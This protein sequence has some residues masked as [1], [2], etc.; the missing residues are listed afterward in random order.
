LRVSGSP[1]VGLAV[2]IIWVGYVHLLGLASTVL[3]LGA[4]GDALPPVVV[5]FDPNGPQRPNGP[6]PLRLSVRSDRPATGLVVEVLGDGA[7]SGADYQLA[8][9]MLPLAPDGTPTPLVVD[10]LENPAR[11]VERTLRLELK[12]SGSG[13]MID[14]SRSVWSVVLPRWAP[15]ESQDVEV[16]FAESRLVV[17]EDRGHAAARLHLEPPPRRPVR[18]P[19]RVGEGPTRELEVGAGQET[20]E[21]AFDVPD[22]QLHSGDRV[23]PIVLQLGTGV[24]PVDPARL[25]VLVRDDEPEPVVRLEPVQDTLAEGSGRPLSFR[26]RVSPKSSGEVTLRCR[27]AGPPAAPGVRLPEVPSWIKLAPGTPEQLVTIPIRDDREPGPDRSFT[28]LFSDATGARLDPPEASL[29]F[30]IRDDDGLP[31]RALILLVQTPD[32]AIETVGGTIKAQLAQFFSEAKRGKG[33]GVL[34]KDAFLVVRKGAEP[35]VWTPG[36]D[37]PMEPAQQFTR[38]DPL[39]VVLNAAFDAA[40]KVTALASSKDALLVV[41]WPTNERISELEFDP[42]KVRKP[43]DRPVRLVVIGTSSEGSDQL[44]KVFSKRGEVVFLRTE[45]RIKD[46]QQ[47]LDDLLDEFDPAAR[48][49]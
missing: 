35:E 15:S 39:D 49:D 43:T 27:L 16:S 5:G 8:A 25:E 29:H 4:G 22:D 46:L 7:E 31:G 1:K 38:S 3:Y 34:L 21:L 10:V 20:A 30:T 47:L 19:Y 37:P 32:L 28:L 45:D 18:V 12:S 44:D 13:V 14:P 17:S 40:A 23:L 24:R 6:G 48:R 9:S 33:S 11:H 36:V 26:V 41:L 2:W 42:Q